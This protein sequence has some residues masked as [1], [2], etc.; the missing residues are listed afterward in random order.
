MKTIVHV[1]SFYLLKFCLF[2]CDIVLVFVDD[3]VRSSREITLNT[4]RGNHLVA[5]SRGS[6]FFRFD[7]RTDPISK[8][9]VSIYLNLDLLGK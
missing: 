8:P 5:L 9:Y 6:V 4:C 1:K 2:L 7:S 3:I